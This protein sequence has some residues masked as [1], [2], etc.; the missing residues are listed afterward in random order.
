MLI[1]QL[2]K[3]KEE[4]DFEDFYRRIS[5]FILDLKK[6]M[7]R[8]IDAAEAQGLI[9]RGFYSAEG[10]L[11]EI[12][13]DFFKDFTNHINLGKLQIILFAKAVRKIEEKKI[14]E[15]ETPEYLST[16]KLL[17]LELKALE[18]KFT[19]QADGDLI[20]YS[21]LD[22]IS[23]KQKNEIPFNVILDETLER[24]LTKKLDLGDVLL[25]SLEK[26]TIFGA[27]YYNIAPRSKSVL[28]LYAFGNRSIKE[29]SEILEVPQNIIQG[30]LAGL[31][32]RFG[33]L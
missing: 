1:K 12:Y 17:E 31:K 10:M 24:Q 19:A 2:N 32:E 13:M 15:Q 6:Y 23:H 25:P 28:E 16:E 8:S 27:L 4:G 14:M 21:E 11:D 5:S 9:D 20:L 26:R 18:E 7:T 33:L 22:D 29:I 30:I 3:Y